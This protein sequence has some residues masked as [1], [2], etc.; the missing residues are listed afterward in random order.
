M[1]IPAAPRW[2][3]PL[4]VQRRGKAPIG[5]HAGPTQLVQQVAQMRGYVGV[6]RHFHNSEGRWNLGLQSG[7]GVAGLL[8][9]IWGWRRRFARAETGCGGKRFPPGKVC[10]RPRVATAGVERHCSS[11]VPVEAAGRAAAASAVPA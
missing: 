3:Q 2:A 6:V 11:P 1:G 7:A 9:E 4:P 8:A 10:L 5:G